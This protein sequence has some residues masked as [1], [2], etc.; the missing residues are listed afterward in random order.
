MDQPYAEVVGSL[1]YLM[2]C[3]RPDLAQS[4]GASLRF[5]SDQRTALG[6]TCQGA[7]VCSGDLGSWTAVWRQGMGCDRLF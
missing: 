6:G 2:T 5:L 7:A 4:V 1:M 3:T